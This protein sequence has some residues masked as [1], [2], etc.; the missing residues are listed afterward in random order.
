MS[1]VN[2]LSVHQI[3][4]YSQSRKSFEIGLNILKINRKNNINITIE[5]K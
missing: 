3:Y 4:M 2:H 5:T 1:I